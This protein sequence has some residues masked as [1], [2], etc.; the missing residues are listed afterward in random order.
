MKSLNRIYCA[1][2]QKFSPI[3]I[4]DMSFYIEKLIKKKCL[5][6]FH[7]SSIK[8]VNNLSLAKKIK[9]F[10]NIKRIK[11]IPKKINSFELIEKRPLFNTLSTNKLKSVCNIKNFKLEYFF[12]KI[13]K[14]RKNNHYFESQRN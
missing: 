13:K 5:G 9:K 10:F 11:I 2:D 1:Y 3:F 6:T 12:K 7:L 8:S 14:D 4:N